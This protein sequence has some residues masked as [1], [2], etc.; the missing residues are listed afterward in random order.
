MVKSK[1]SWGR[2]LVWRL[3]E[4]FSA[5]KESQCNSQSSVSTC[6]PL[7]KRAMSVAAPFI[8]GVLLNLFL[9]HLDDL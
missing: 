9:P 4:L 5:V 1:S 2:G 3:I 7:Q 6:Q 8:W